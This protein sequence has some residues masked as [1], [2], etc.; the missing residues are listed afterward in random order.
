MALGGLHRV[1]ALPGPGKPLFADLGEKGPAAGAVLALHLLNAP[2]HQQE[3]DLGGQGQIVVEG[4][5]NLQIVGSELLAQSPLHLVAQGGEGGGL[6]A[7]GGGDVLQGVLR[8]GGLGDGSGRDGG[9]L[10]GGH[11]LALESLQGGLFAL[12][13]PGEPLQAVAAQQM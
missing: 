10:T 4:V 12:H 11:A 3:D 6:V 5:E 1:D 8:R 13:R 7:E 9:E 2:A